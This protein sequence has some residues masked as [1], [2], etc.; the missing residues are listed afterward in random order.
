[1]TVEEVR[2]P[3][4][5]VAGFCEKWGV[6]EFAVFGSVL[7]D[8]F[9]PHSDLDVLVRFHASHQPSLFGLSRMESELSRLVGRRVDVSEREAVEQSRNHIRRDAILRSARTIYASDTT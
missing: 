1:M 9:G 3:I 5:Q 8:D 7:R 4:A 2:L 6:M